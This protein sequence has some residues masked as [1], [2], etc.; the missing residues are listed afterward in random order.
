MLIVV[1]QDVG[2]A[3]FT[4]LEGA[5]FSLFS[6]IMASFATRAPRPYIHTAMNDRNDPDA[7]PASPCREVCLLD[8]SSG[9]C[10]GCLRSVEEITAWRDAPASEK[11]AILARV[12]QRRAATGAVP[13]DN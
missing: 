12:A 7:D 6:Q 10:K 11:R 5:D 8:R 9:L 1:P 3:Q 4:D 2:A 13:P